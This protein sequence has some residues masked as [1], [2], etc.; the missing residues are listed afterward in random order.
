MLYFSSLD[1][2]SYRGR[3]YIAFLRKLR[4]PLWLV[5]YPPRPKRTS[6]SKGSMGWDVSMTR[7]GFFF[8]LLVVD[9]DGDEVF[10]T[11]TTGE[12]VVG[13]LCTILGPDRGGIG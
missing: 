2:V 6:S 3:S 10:R 7:R 13:K 5:V 9:E 4:L 1:T 8:P 11:D 12:V